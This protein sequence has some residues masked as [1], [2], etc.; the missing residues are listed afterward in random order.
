VPDEKMII[1]ESVKTTPQNT[2]G[3]NVVQNRKEKT[4]F[5]LLSDE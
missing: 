3:A 1:F 2:C 5:P 4:P